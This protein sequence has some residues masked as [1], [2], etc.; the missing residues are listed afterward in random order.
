MPFGIIP[1]Q[2]R[3][4]KTEHN[5]HF[6]GTDPCTQILESRAL[7]TGGTGL[8]LILINNVDLIFGP[9]QC[10]GTLAQ[11]ILTDLTLCIIPYLALP[12]S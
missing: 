10:N 12:C 6:S 8:A 4:F 7:C 11:A 9:A 1:A 5:A 2:A 3:Y